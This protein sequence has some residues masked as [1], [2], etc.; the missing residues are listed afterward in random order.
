[1]KLWRF[2]FTLAAPV[3]AIGFAYAWWADLAWWMLAI[4]AL[5]FVAQ[6]KIETKPTSSPTDPPA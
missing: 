1:M 4:L 5:G 3:Y 6:F 2:S